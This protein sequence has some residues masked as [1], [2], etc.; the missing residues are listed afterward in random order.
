MICQL[1]DINPKGLTLITQS[2]FALPA[3][4]SFLDRRLVRRS[5]NEGGSLGVGGSLG[6]GG[7]EVWCDLAVQILLGVVCGA[8][9]DAAN[10][11]MN[12]QPPA[13]CASARRD[14]HARKII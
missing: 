2:L 3:N 13:A 9:W 14:R 12:P 10:V 8:V 7:S 1:E 5:F 4:R 6:E 11:R